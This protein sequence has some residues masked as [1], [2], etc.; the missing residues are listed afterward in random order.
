MV[1]FTLGL[2]FATLVSHQETRLIARRKWN[3]M[4]RVFLLYT[5]HL[6]LLNTIILL[7]LLSLFYF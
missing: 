2:F 7:L 5:T 4:F 1:L 3:R 6:W